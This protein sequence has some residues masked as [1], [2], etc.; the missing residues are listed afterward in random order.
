MA[1]HTPEPVEVLFRREEHFACGCTSTRIE[2]ILLPSLDPQLCTGHRGE[3]LRSVVT[4]EYRPAQA[5]K[6]S[7][8]LHEPE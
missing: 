2:S 3:L 8:G 5:H 1:L 6:E 4:T 7:I